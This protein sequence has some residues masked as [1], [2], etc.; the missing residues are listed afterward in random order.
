MNIAQQIAQQMM[1]SNNGAAAAGLES[2][3]HNTGTL[4]IML[5]RTQYSAFE[6]MNLLET[7]P[8]M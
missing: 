4:T 7:S 1:M 3:Y 6:N 5:L 2:N 8:C